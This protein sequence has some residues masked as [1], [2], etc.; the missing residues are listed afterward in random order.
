M[1]ALLNADSDCDSWENTGHDSPSYF[2]WIDVLCPIYFINFN[3]PTSDSLNG[4]GWKMG[5]RNGASH[6]H[7]P[8]H[9]INLINVAVAAARASVFPSSLFLETRN[10]R[11][12]IMIYN[13][14]IVMAIANH[15]NGIPFSQPASLAKIALRP[16]VT[17]WIPMTWKGNQFGCVQT[18]F[19]HVVFVYVLFEID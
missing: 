5:K 13:R 14:L 19:I 1:V 7:L 15:R 9:S 11:I 6:E 16:T 17:Y 10:S 18:I 12:R 3:S 2:E 8:N 4:F